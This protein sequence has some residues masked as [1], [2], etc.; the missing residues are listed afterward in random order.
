MP[1][2][3]LKTDE[4]YEGQSP[5]TPEF[6]KQLMSG[7]SVIMV[8][9]FLIY[10][11]VAWPW[12]V[13]FN[14]NTI[15]GLIQSIGLGFLPAT[16][17]GVVLILKYNIAGASGFVGGIFASAVF[18]FLRIQ[19]FALGNGSHD[20]PQTEYPATWAYFVPLAMIFISIGLSAIF[21]PKQPK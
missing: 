3:P 14:A 9:C 10:F 7:C 5:A 18:V 19:Q 8:S 20:L 16:I 4:P 21:W 11:L 12:F 13:F 1:F 6:E 17:A 2:E 15:S